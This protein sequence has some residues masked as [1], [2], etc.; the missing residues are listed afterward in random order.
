MGRLM[1]SWFFDCGGG[2]SVFLGLELGLVG[3]LKDLIGFAHN[4]VVSV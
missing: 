3:F 2:P 4:T 1:G